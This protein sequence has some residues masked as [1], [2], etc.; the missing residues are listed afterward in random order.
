MPMLYALIFT[1]VLFLTPQVWAADY[2][3]DAAAIVKAADWDGAETLTVN[4]LEHEFQPKTLKLKAGQP[5]KIELKNL[6]QQHH[7]FVAPVFF[8]SVAWRKLMVK[9][10]AE[11]KVDYVNA[12]EVLKQGG[13]LD[14]YLVPVSTGVFEV[15][16]TVPGHRE[17]GMKGQ[18]IVE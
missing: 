4:L 15:T 7:Y 9:E 17:M 3:T 6:G 12:V 18:I 2:I 16:C 8:R 1:L 10:Q 14:L 5:Y 13:Q 11:I